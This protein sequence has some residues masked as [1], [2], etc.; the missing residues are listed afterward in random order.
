[1]VKAVTKIFNTFLKR[2]TL[3]LVFCLEIGYTSYEHNTSSTT[4]VISVIVVS[5][6]T[7]ATIGGRLVVVI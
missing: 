2:P 4:I 1:M 6:T 7:I 5:N 3:L